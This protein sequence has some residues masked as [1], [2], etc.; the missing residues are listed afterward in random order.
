MNFKETQFLKYLK[1]K[2]KVRIPEYIYISKYK[3]LPDIN[4][5]WLRTEAINI[6]GKRKNCKIISWFS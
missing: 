2:V 1:K 4:T 6:I 5:N 3:S